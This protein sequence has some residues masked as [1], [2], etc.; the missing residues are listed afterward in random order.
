[1]EAPVAV[2]NTARLWMDAT[3]NYV[4]SSGTTFVSEWHDVRETKAEAP[5]DYPR[6]V[7][8]WNTSTAANAVANALPEVTTL[9]NGKQAFWFGGYRSGRYMAFLSPSESDPAATPFSLSDITEAFIVYSFTNTF[10]YLFGKVSGTSD[11]H[12][13]SS[14]MNPSDTF[15]GLV[16]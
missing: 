1:M 12:P 4:L 10:T 15:A 8:R 13:G 9:D 7:S 2:L 16:A 6:A 5:F 14:N 11:F 3:R